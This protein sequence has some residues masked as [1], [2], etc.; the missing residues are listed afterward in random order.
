MIRNKRWQIITINIFA[1]L[2]L[3]AQYSGLNYKAFCDMPFELKYPLGRIAEMIPYATIGYDLA[4]FGVFDWINEKVKCKHWVFLGALIILLIQIVII[5]IPSMQGFGYSGIYRIVAALLTF[6]VFYCLPIQR[7]G[8]RGKRALSV[9]TGHTLGVYCMHY[10]IGNILV[11]GTEKIGLSLN[12]LILCLLI[13]IICYSLSC[14][15]SMIP[16]KFL[17]GLVD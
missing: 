15:I 14:L 17:E 16:N 6:A 11:T 8:E 7:I 10:L 1:V 2:A 3:V 9:I 13:Y 4:H 12:F 5:P